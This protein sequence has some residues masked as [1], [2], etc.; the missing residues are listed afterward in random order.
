MSQTSQIEQRLLRQYLR[1]GLL[2]K[3]VQSFQNSTYTQLLL[4]LMPMIQ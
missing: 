1:A 4:D 3:P 2:N